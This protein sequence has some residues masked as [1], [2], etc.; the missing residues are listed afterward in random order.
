MVFKDHAFNSNQNIH[1]IFIVSGSL[2][3]GILCSHFDGAGKR[4]YA[5][6]F[7]SAAHFLACGQC[8]TRSRRNVRYITAASVGRTRKLNNSAGVPYVSSAIPISLIGLESTIG[9][10]FYSCFEWA[11]LWWHPASSCLFSTYF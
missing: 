10:I 7:Y 6:P 1:F 9:S 8:F 3:Y 4:L 11:S 5:E 2:W